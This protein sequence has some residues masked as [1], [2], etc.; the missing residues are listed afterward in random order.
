MK[1]IIVKYIGIKKFLVKDDA[2]TNEIK[3]LFER[4]VAKLHP[5]WGNNIKAVIYA[6]DIPEG[7][8]F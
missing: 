4:D 6:E 7:E 2:T 8:A 3:K 1:Q 5:S